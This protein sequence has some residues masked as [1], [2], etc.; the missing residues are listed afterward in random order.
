[1][2]ERAMNK[3]QARTAATRRHA[4][5]NCESKYEIRRGWDRWLGEVAGHREGSTAVV[6]HPFWHGL[7]AM[8]GGDGGGEGGGRMG[9]GWRR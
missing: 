8:V 2:A 7:Y 5:A 4:R 9:L 1:M 3:T 6:E